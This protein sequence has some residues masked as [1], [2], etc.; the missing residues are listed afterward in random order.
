MNPFIKKEIRILLPGFSIGVAVAFANLFVNK[1]DSAFNG[2]AIFTSFIVCPALALFM[3]LNSFGTEISAG[4]FSMLLA[5]PVSRRQIWRTKTS[6]LALALFGGGLIW[7]VIVCLY[8]G[9]LHV[10]DMD[11]VQSLFACFWLFLLSIY[12]GSLWTVL[13]LRQVAAAF[14]FTLLAPCAITVSIIGLVGEDNVSVRWW[15][16]IVALLIYNAA[17]FMFAR[18]LFLRAQDVQ[19]SGGAISLPKFRSTSNFLAGAAKKRFWRPKLA[20]LQKELQLHQSQFIMAGVLLG[21]HLIVLAM[22]KFGHYHPNSSTLLILE[23]FWMLWL[24]MPVLVGAAAISE[25]RKLG[26]LGGQ[27]CLPVRQRTQ[28]LIKLCT[29]LFLS[30]VFGA[31]IPILL[32]RSRILLAIHLPTIPDLAS[33]DGHAVTL[34]LIYNTF[35]AFSAL[36]FPSFIYVVLATVLGIISFYASSLARNTLQALAPAILGILVFITLM[37]TAYRT[38][39]FFHY[40]L[41]RGFLIYVI[42]LPILV[43]ALLMISFWNF[44]RITVNWNVWLRNLLGFAAALTIAIA[45]TTAIYHRFWEKLTPFEPP[46]GTARLSLSNPPALNSRWYGISVRL[47]DGKI[48]NGHHLMNMGPPDLFG[49]LLGNFRMINYGN[50]SF[51]NGSNW[52]ALIYM[53]SRQMMGLKNNGTLWVSH[54]PERFVRGD[55][56]SSAYG[57][58]DASDIRMEQYGSDTNWTSFSP[59]GRLAVLTKKDGTLWRWGP[60]D[61]DEKNHSWPD[62]QTF[63]PERVGT[64][65]NWAAIFP[66]D[67]QVHFRKTDGSDWMPRYNDKSTLPSIQLWK[68]FPIERELDLDYDKFRSVFRSWGGTGFMLGIRDNG[69]FMMLANH[70]YASASGNYEWT[71]LNLPLSQETNWLVAAGRGEK[72]VTLKKDGSLWLW[73]FHHDHSHGWDPQWEEREMLNTTPARLGTHSEWIA[74]AEADGGIVSLAADGSLW[75][76][77]LEDVGYFAQLHPEFFWDSGKNDYFLPL[78]DISRKPQFLANLFNAAN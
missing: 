63:T 76:W 39:L 70:I 56:W 33:Y 71:P 32:E 19:W 30:V 59:L 42:G 9:L 51:Y 12:S 60:L 69:T 28:F 55:D 1:D 5:Q 35:A 26:T 16:T 13:L 65:S 58:M 21:L 77:P 20:L 57:Q 41:W 49:S 22:R 50:D 72:I 24:V 47:P 43:I 11:D 48:W 68:K 6:L 25:E 38:D 15:M 36:W 74:I 62:Y 75:Y 8:G 23:S 2:V 73:N 34:A 45:S 52:S 27:L 17:G 29:V 78:L 4:T 7:Y 14:W 64:E 10:L 66:S 31:L 46:H 67:Y 53:P 54:A 40:P 61:W 18:W 44:Q 3:A 37:T